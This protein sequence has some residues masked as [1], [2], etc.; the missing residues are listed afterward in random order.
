MEVSCG[1]CLSS[2]R[3]GCSI[4][5]VRGL[6]SAT[7]AVLAASRASVSRGPVGGVEWNDLSVRAAS[8]DVSL[9][10]ATSGSA[11]AGRLLALL[12]P[13]GAGKPGA[14]CR[15]NDVL[16]LARVPRKLSNT[17]FTSVCLR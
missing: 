9:L 10:H 6:V 7:L 1:Y 3:F 14:P 17:G 16:A 15:S 4:T 12:G 5:M 2:A 11:R 8:S 13:S